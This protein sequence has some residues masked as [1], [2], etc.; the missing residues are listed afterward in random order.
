MFYLLVL[1]VQR[2]EF[3]GAEAAPRHLGDDPG[4]AGPVIREYRR[5]LAFAPAV[6]RG[7]GDADFDDQALADLGLVLLGK[8]G[9]Q[10][11]ETC[12]SV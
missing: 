12:F 11:L 10:V 9:P 2:E 1:F 7:V 5:A 3:L 8:P 4:G 6:Q